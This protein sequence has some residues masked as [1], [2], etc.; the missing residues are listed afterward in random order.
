MELQTGM[1]L[2]GG[3]YILGKIAKEE[4]IRY[5]ELGV[6][7]V[8]GGIA[9]PF[10]TTSPAGNGILGGMVGAANTAATNWIYGEDKDV[11]EAFRDGFI[12]SSIGTATAS[13]IPIGK[14]TPIFIRDIVNWSISNTPS[15]VSISPFSSS[16]KEGDGK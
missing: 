10:A 6:N 13:K 12:F 8:T 2:G 7:L 5:G 1:E 11:R 15:F 3:F 16:S 14:S 4:E 9:G